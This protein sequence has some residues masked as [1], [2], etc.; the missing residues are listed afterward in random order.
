MEQTHLQERTSFR[1][2]IISNKDELN[3]NSRSSNE[4]I[5]NSGSLK[6]IE[7]KIFGSEK[8][9]SSEVIRRDSIAK[10]ITESNLLCRDENYFDIKKQ[11]SN[12]SNGDSLKTSKKNKDNNNYQDNNKNNYNNQEINLNKSF[13][14]NEEGQS[15]TNSRK[16]KLGQLRSLK[17]REVDDYMN[18]VF[19]VQ[20]NDN[21][22]D[23]RDEEE[24]KKKKLNNKTTKDKD[25][26]CLGSTNKN[27]EVKFSSFFLIKN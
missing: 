13:G 2:T 15:Q 11:F 8:R 26:C 22:Y 17:T 20:N 6:T 3:R 9:L 21:L 14:K 5:T 23:Q 4:I 25:Y 1:I 12:D 19:N 24:V 10:K 7:N 18:D 27:E 16:N